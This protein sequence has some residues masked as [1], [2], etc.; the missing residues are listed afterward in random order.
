MRVPQLDWPVDLFAD[1][2]RMPEAPVTISVD[3]EILFD[4]EVPFDADLPLWPAMQE[5]WM[6]RATQA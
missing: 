5:L 1:E 6:E 4:A 3:P 2:V